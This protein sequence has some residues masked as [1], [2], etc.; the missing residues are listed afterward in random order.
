MEE[1]TLVSCTAMF[2]EVSDEEKIVR[3]G[4]RHLALH[5][6][7]VLIDLT[8]WFPVTVWE[9]DLPKLENK[10]IYSVQSLSVK[11]LGSTYLSTTV[12]TIIDHKPDLSYPEEVVDTLTMQAFTGFGITK[13]QISQFQYA[14]NFAVNV[15]CKACERR[16]IDIA[17]LQVVKCSGP[18]CQVSQCIA[19]CCKVGSLRLSITAEGED[20]W[21]AVKDDVLVCKLQS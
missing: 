21:L 3:I 1:G 4:C 19:D 16:L 15:R 17:S 7:C 5:E 14:D 9:S 10:K 12:H 6:K 13:R 2:L 11:Q 20:I 8:S 18:F